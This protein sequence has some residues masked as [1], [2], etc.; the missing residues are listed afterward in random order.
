[1][2]SRNTIY[3]LGYHIP[4]AAQGTRCLATES[5]TTCSGTFEAVW[6]V[7]NQSRPFDIAIYDLVGHD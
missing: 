5:L 6:S 1:M 2:N 3:L 7:C 4:A